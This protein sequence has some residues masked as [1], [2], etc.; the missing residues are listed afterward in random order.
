MKRRTFLSVAAAAASAQINQTSQCAAGD[1]SE[2]NAKMRVAV[3]GHTQRGN[4]GHGLDTVWLRLPEEAQIVAVAD[5]NVAG[6]ENAKRKLKLTSGFLDYREMLMRSKPDIVA[7][8]PRHPDQHHAM[9][10][11]AIQA[12]A[13]GVY[14]EKPFC[15]TP[16]ESDEIVAACT[17]RNVKLAVAHRNRYHPTLAAIDKMIDS[18][19]LGK[20]LEI[21]GRGKG[22]RRG[23]GE[24]LWVLGCHI[25]NLFHYFGGPPR[26][27]S[28]IIKTGG[29]SVTKSDVVEGNEALGPLAGD[30]IHARF[31]MPRWPVA[32][33]DSIANDETANQG[34]GLQLIG[35]EGVIDIKIDRDPLAHWIAGNPFAISHKG[36]AWVP[37]HSTGAGAPETIDGL[38]DAVSHHEIAARDLIESIRD[39]R[40]PLC[41]VHEAA[42]T[43]EMICAVFA[44]HQQQGKSVP[45][46]LTQRDNALLR[47]Q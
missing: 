37:I 6:L 17:Q 14:C 42:M 1:P 11:A 35:S 8:C 40:Q 46:P 19:T 47:L 26:S 41:N 32:Y 7:V 3:I 39:D 18:G 21:R 15:R 16:S 2:S 10:M 22:D 24:D 29:R 9:T 44:S 12:G 20:P 23:G 43:V 33:F 28:A 30:E 45:I 27:C 36:R 38:F 13:R 5:A 31:E 34:F 4:F 25:F